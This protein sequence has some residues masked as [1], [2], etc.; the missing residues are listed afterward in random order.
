M[1]REAINTAQ[2]EMLLAKLALRKDRE[3]LKEMDLLMRKTVEKFRDAA[4]R[5][6]ASEKNYKKT[7]DRYMELIKN[8]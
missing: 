4:Q 5:M 3:F 1:D 6:K 8:A 7:H 2:F